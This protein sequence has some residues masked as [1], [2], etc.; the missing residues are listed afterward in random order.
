MTDQQRALTIQAADELRGR[1]NNSACSAIF[2][3][4]AG[5]FRSLQRERDWLEDCAAL[6]ETLG[7]WRTFVPQSS[8]GFDRGQQILLDGH[9]SFEKATRT[10]E[11]GWSLDSG[12]ARLLWLAIA[13]GSKS[14]IIIPGQSLRIQDPPPANDPANRPSVTSSDQPAHSILE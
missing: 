7:A 2:N 1:F 14:R 13:N 9:A 10:V 5:S 6:R 11:I 8:F 4:A 12:R 3:E